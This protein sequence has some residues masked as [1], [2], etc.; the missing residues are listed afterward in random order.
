MT[1]QKLDTFE[2]PSF[3]KI[4]SV[5]KSFTYCSASILTLK[6]IT[7]NLSLCFSS[8]IFSTI[9]NQPQND[10]I[11]NLFRSLW[12]LSYL[13]CLPI[14]SDVVNTTLILYCHYDVIVPLL[15]HF[16]TPNCRLNGSVR[17]NICNSK[18][19][20]F[21]RKIRQAFF[22]KNVRKSKVLLLK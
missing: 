15:A 4:E 22:M 7:E 2:T 19:I 5:N 1:S 17:I 3:K 16:L 11:H 6:I 10:M 21:Y 20:D 9:I 18:I 13:N 14:V 8:E 12:M